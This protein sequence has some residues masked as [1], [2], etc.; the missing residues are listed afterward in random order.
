MFCAA[1]VDRC[2]FVLRRSS[3]TRPLVE[4]FR[5]NVSQDARSRLTLILTGPARRPGRRSVKE[6]RDVPAERLY[7]WPECAPERRN[8]ASAASVCCATL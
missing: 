1:R 4:T 2:G 8:R 6:E 5:G 7:A 3:S